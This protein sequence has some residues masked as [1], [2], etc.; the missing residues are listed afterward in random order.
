[1]H[2]SYTLAGGREAGC[3]Y[4]SVCARLYMYIYIHMW[5]RRKVLEGSDVGEH[6]AAEQPHGDGSRQI[7]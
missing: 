3:I 2:R 6:V 5:H 4:M 7:V 1:M